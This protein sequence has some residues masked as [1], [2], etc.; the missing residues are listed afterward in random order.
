MATEAPRMRSEPYFAM[1]PMISAPAMGTKTLYTPRWCPNGR[2]D[3][4]SDTSRR[5]CGRYDGPSLRKAVRIRLQ[6][7]AVRIAK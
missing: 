5:S 3:V 7:R 2:S 6:S 4:T 1:T